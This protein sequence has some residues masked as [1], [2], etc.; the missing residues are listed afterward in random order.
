LLYRVC[1]ITDTELDTGFLLG[2][3]EVYR[4]KGQKEL[5]E[6]FRSLISEKKIGLIAVQED[7]FPE[8]KK[9]FPKELK[10]GWPLI[11]PFPSAKVQEKKR[12]HIAEMIKEAI[13]YYVKLR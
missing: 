4:V 7:F 11:I 5:L 6:T 13:G 8:L 12:D 2:G 10:S 3:A 1:F 9:N